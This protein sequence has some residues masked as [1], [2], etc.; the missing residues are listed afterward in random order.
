MNP[1]LLIVDLFCGAGGATTGFMNNSGCMVIACVNHDA[2]AIKSHSANHPDCKHFTEDV[3]N[4]DLNKLKVIADKYRAMYPDARLILWAS[5]ECTNFSKAKGGQPRDGDS[6]S[7]ADHMEQYVTALQPEYFMIE[8]VVEFMSWGPLTAKISRTDEGYDCCTFMIVPNWVVDDSEFDGAEYDESGDDYERVN[9][10]LINKKEIEKQR[11]DGWKIVY[12]QIPEKRKNGSDYMRWRNEIDALGYYNDWR[13]LNAA[14]FGAY[15]SRN[16]LF[17]IFAQHGMPIAW[18]DATHSKKPSH[19]LFGKSLLKWKPVKDVLDF[20]DEGK[21]IFDRKKELSDKTLER[22]MAGLIKFVAGGKEAFILKYNS[23]SAKGVHVPPSVDEPCPTIACQNR[24]GIAF[25]QKYYSGRPEGMVIPVSGPVD[26]ITTVDH[27]NLVQAS[28]LEQRNSGDPAGRVMSIDQPAR[29]LTSTA[30][31]QDIVNPCFIQKYHGNGDNLHSIDAPCPTIAT[32]DQVAVVRPEYLISY[33]HSST[34]NDINSPCPTLT[35]KDRDAL[36]KPCFI[37][38]DFTGGGQTSSIDQ[39]AGAVMPS[40]KLNLVTPTPFVM[41]TNFDNQ[42]ASIEE[43]LSTITANRKWHYL[44]NPSHGGNVSDTNAPCPVVVARQDK[45]PLYLVV[46]E[47]GDV[48]IRMDETDT[49]AMIKIK[50]F[51]VLYG[52]VDIKMRMLKIPELLKIQGFPENYTLIGTQADQK[53]FIGNAVHP[54]VPD[55]MAKA[56]IEKLKVNNTKAA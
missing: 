29:T 11:Q 25:I 48:A 41:A 7:L 2:N 19:S 54:L 14:N 47:G 37:M 9:G 50:K 45:A 38:R 23:T 34:V 17:G 52:I 24:L 22:I 4:M 56:L 26:A 1:S 20:D 46:S 16:R 8:N 44:V 42:P 36:V 12:P 32:K 43:P 39:P 21:S 55:A 10:V 49:P 31:N 28:F 35:C 30:G 5:L 6:R 15:T 3:R 18:P 40:P 51:M 27:H 33:Q 13:E 53:K